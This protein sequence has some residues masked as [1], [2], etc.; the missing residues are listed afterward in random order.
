M[1]AQCAAHVFGLPVVSHVCM[2]QTVTPVGNQIPVPTP[3]PSTPDASVAPLT[4]RK[5][6]MLELLKELQERVTRLEAQAAGGAQAGT[7]DGTPPSEM[8]SPLPPAETAKGS[9]ETE[10]RKGVDSYTPNL[11]FKLADT[12]WLYL[13]NSPVGYSSVPFAV[14]GRGNVF[15]S[16]VELAF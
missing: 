14:G 16:S 7:A 9:Q 4:D 2:A 1:S 3:T 10:E 12:E 5:R 8:E 13:F 6:A 11:G 15:H